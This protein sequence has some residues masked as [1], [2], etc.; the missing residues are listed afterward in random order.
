M[1]KH[2]TFYTLIMI[3]IVWSMQTGNTQTLADF[4][5]YNLNPG[6]FLNDASPA[7]VFESGSIELFNYFDSEFNFW[8]D[9]AISADTNSTS[10]GF[11]NQYSAITGQGAL[12][13][14][15]YAVGYIFDP[16]TIRLQP[17]AIGKP[18][19]GMYVTNSTYTYLSMRDGD[20]FAKKFG[21][22][23]GTDPDFLL[24]TFKKYS[25]GVLSSD[26]I[27]FYLADYRFN[28]SNM[29]FLVSDWTYVDLTALGS[30]DSLSMQ[31]TSTD[32]GIFGMNTPSYVCIDQ[33]TTDDLQLAEIPTS[34]AS[35]ISISPN[36]VSDKLYIDIKSEGQCMIVNMQGH[37]IQ[38]AYYKAGHYEI[39]V[40][41]W[42]TGIYVV[43]QNEGTPKRFSVQ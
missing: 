36:P 43:R 32:N 19:I 41:G 7:S 10:P 2:F 35:N 30:M 33:V 4:E 23:T 16:I 8:A 20:S 37:V 9:W 3:A 39:S 13:S 22:E 24:I 25:E 34:R 21:G 38:S 6:E 40:D 5:E 11:L 15:T 14:N 18:M 12:N 26:S 29:D 17:N 42:P 1:R 27:N 28:D 31:M